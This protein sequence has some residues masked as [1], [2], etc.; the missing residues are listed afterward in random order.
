MHWFG[1]YD[2]MCTYT[3]S[4]QT[5]KCSALFALAY[6]EIWDKKSPYFFNSKATNKVFYAYLLKDLHLLNLK[7]GQ[8][9]NSIK[10]L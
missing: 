9:A 7:R 4:T 6:L 5:S 10:S 8:T 1:K 3:Y 2:F